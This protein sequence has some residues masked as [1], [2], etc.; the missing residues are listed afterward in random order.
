MSVH[1]I[2]SC[3]DCASHCVFD[4]VALSHVLADPELRIVW[5]E[6]RLEAEARKGNLFGYSNASDGAV[7]FGVFLDERPPDFLL[8][9]SKHSAKDL[10]LRVP[11]GNLWACGTE[12]VSHEECA[13]G[14]PESF[15]LSLEHMGRK[16]K[17]PAGD[18]LVDAYE[19]P[20]PASVWPQT[21]CSGCLLALGSIASVLLVAL[22]TVDFLARKGAY[23]LPLCI[24][25]GLGL[26]LTVICVIVGRAREKTRAPAVPTEPQS[27][28]DVVLHLRQLPS[29]ISHSYQ[30]GALWPTPYRAAE[31]D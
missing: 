23:A 12:Y 14:S 7:L 19:L 29:A 15:A 5:D 18:Y 31:R 9:L 8:S 13:E 28:Y 24:V 11:S 17:V 20:G 3:T 2:T 16:L 21:S 10:L 22:G 26:L 6:Q 4:P 1:K 27:E 30:G 25:G